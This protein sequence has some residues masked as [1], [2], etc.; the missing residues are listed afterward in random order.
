[1]RLHSSWPFLPWRPGRTSCFVLGRDGRP[2]DNLGPRDF[3]LTVD[4]NPR[5]VVS[6]E[7]VEAAAP[8]ARALTLPARHF[9]SNE[10]LNAG[11]LVV[12]AVDQMHIRRLE[13]RRALSAAARFIDSLDPLDRV[14]V[15]SL[16]RTASV[17]FTRDHLALKHRLE[18]IVGQGDPVFLQFNIGLAEASEIADGGRARLADV[19]LRECG[20]ALTD[21]VNT[22]RAADD[23]RSKGS[24]RA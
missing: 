22:A 3:V 7:F 12:V 14:A 9:T 21:S 10:D 17:E 19:V 8:A 15:T 13:G 23:A 2:V 1:M 6:A 16:N 4:G 20:R 24:S 5:P 18:T 11:R